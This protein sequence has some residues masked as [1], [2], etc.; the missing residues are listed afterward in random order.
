MLQ[1][2][3]CLAREY[4]RQ[5]TLYG[6]Q[7]LLKCILLLGAFRQYTVSYGTVQ[8]VHCLVFILTAAIETYLVQS[9]YLALT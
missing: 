2:T 4:G 6:L 1:C 9:A 7:I 8:T 3:Q 5:A